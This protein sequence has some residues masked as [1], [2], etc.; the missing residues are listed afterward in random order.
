MS[1]HC[2]CCQKMVVPSVRYKH[3]GPSELYGS[4]AGLHQLIDNKVPV[5]IIAKTLQFKRAIT[6]MR[7][8][9]REKGI[10]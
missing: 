9:Q 10:K 4:L 3:L 6:A 5:G 8:Y 1:Q 2:R 7:A